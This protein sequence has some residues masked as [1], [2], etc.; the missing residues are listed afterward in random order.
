MDA[1]CDSR[2]A[3]AVGAFSSLSAAWGIASP[4][5]REWGRLKIGPAGR[6][7]ITRSLGRFVSELELGGVI[8]S[9]LSVLRLDCLLWYI[10]Q[11]T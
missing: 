5:D 11:P 7:I 10:Y 8:L 1:I 6:L 2:S 3:S 9:S 4:D